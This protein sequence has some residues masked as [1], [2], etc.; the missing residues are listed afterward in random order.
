MVVWGETW[1]GTQVRCRCDNQ[2]IVAVLA[3][4]SSWE[5]HIM[6]LLRCLFFIEAHY[7]CQLSASYITTQD[8]TIA[9]HLSRNKLMAFFSNLPQADNEPTPIPPNLPPLLLNPFMDWLSPAWTR[10]F[11]STFDWD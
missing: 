4:R 9:D 1:R 5:T 3:V 11:R 2:A 7:Q 10:Q 6:H 8:N